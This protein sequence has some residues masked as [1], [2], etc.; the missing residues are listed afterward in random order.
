MGNDEKIWDI[1]ASGY[2]QAEKRFE[3]VAVKTIEN[4]KKYLHDD[5][6][7]LDYGCAKGSKTFLLAGFVKRIYGIDISSRMIEG[8]KRKAIERKIDNVEFTQTT[9]FD[10]RFQRASF[11][12]I[13]AYN[14]FHVIKDHRQIIHRMTELLKSGGLLICM[15]PCLREKMT[16]IHALKFYPLILLI[17]IGLLPAY[18]KRFK[19]SELEGLINH[20][21]LQIVE[22]EKM[23]L[24]FTGYFIVAKK[25]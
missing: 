6:I 11:D 9:I 10:E 24:D 25:K 7:V 20:G 19:I 16:V 17:N 22:T 2:D 14:I 13:L 3:P 21:N 4:T 8:A 12:A 23:F 5:D 1:I 18:L 15:T